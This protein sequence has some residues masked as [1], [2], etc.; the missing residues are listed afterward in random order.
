MSVKSYK[1][2]ARLFR[3]VRPEAEK[4][5]SAR[6]QTIEGLEERLLLTASPSVQNVAP[7]ANATGVALNAPITVNVNLPNGGLAPNSVI[8]ANVYLYPSNNSS[9]SGFVPS[10][11]NTTGGGDAIILTPSVNLQ[12]NTKYV[13]SI[14]NGVKDVN[15]DAFTP[16]TESFTTNNTAPAVN[17]SI[18]FQKVALPTTAGVPF[19]DM[20]IGPDSKLYASTEDGRIFRFVINSD[21]TLGTP[22]IFTTLQTYEGGNRLITGFAFDPNSTATN[23][24]L[25]V[26]NTYYALSGATN[27]PNFTSKLT[28]M[29]GANLTNVVDAVVNLPRSVADHVND[30]PVFQ[31]GTSN[32]FFCQAGQNAYGAPDTTWGNRAETLLS[33]AILEVN[34]AALNLS[35]PALNVLTPDVGGTYNPYAAAAPVTIYA[36]GVRNAFSLY[37]DST[38]QLWA[39]LNGSSSGGNTP[40]FSSSNASQ[41]NGNR[42]DTGAPYAGPNVPGL[43]NVPQVEDD[44]LA[45]IVQGGYY[46]HPDPVRGE[47]VLDDGNP[48][49]GGV[50]GLVFTNYP[51]GTNPD[52]NYRVSDIFIMG[53][54][55]SPDAIFAYTA[56]FAAPDPFGGAL[57]NK[58]LIA[59]YSAGDDIAVVSRTAGDNVSTDANQNVIADRSISGFSA[60]TNPLALLE[61]PA[62][63]YIYVSELGGNDL[64]LLKP[65]AVPVQ[66][67]VTTLAGNNA[68]A[69]NTISTGYTGATASRVETVTITNTGTNP[70][71]FG[72]GALSIINDPTTTAN[73]ARFT[74]TNAASLP[75]SLAAGASFAISLKYTATIVGTQSAILQI[76]SNDP[77]NPTFSVNLHGIGTA[78]QYGV[79]EPSLVQVLRANNIPTIVGAGPNDVNINTQKYPASPDPSSEEVA[80]QRMVVAGPGPVTI[81]PIAS[82]ST[83]T[84]AVS[85]IGY[86]TPGDPLDDTELFYIAKADAQTVSPSAVGATSFN[87]GSAPFSL[88][89]TFPGTTTSNGSLDTHY[90]EDAFNTLDP[91]NERKFRFFPMKTANG[92]VVPNTYIVAIE[93]Y[94]DPTTYNSFINF[95]GIISNVRPA[96]NAN[97]G[98]TP[99]SPTGNNLPVMGVQLNGTAPGS[100]NLVFNTINIPNP[101]APDVVHNTNT[102]TINNTGD[103]PLVITSLTLSDTKNWTLVNPPASGTSIAGGGSLTVT[104]KF[105]ATTNPSHTANETNDIATDSGVSSVAAG[106]VWTGTLTINSNDPIKP[107]QK[108]SLTGYWQYQT[109]HENEP[110]LPTITNLLLGYTTNDTGAASTQGTELLNNGNTV[111]MY[112]SEVDPSTDQGL[113]VAADPTQP[114]SLLEAAAFH[115][116]YQTVTATVGTTTYG[117]Q[118]ASESGTTVTITTTGPNPFKPGNQ[119]TIAGVAVAGYNGTF[120][121]LATPTP[122]TFTY[123]AKA[124]LAASA[125]APTSPQ[126]GWYAVGSTSSHYLFRDQAN[127]GQSVFPLSTNDSYSTVQTSFTPTGAFGLSL[128]G[129]KSQDSLNAAV[130]TPFNTGGHAL[131]FFPVIDSTGKIVPNTWLVTM[132]YRDYAGPNSDYQDLVEI[133]TNATFQALPPTPMDLQATQGTAGVNLQWAAMNGATGYNVYQVVNGTPV[134]LNPSPITTASYTDL[135]APAGSVVKYQVIAVNAAGAQSLAASTSIN[136]AGYTAPAPTQAP[137]APATLTATDNSATQVTLGWSAVIGASSY[138]VQRQATGDATWTTLSA[139]FTNGTTFVD[140]SALPSTNYTYQVAAQNSVGTSSFTQAQTTTIAAT[141]GAYQSADISSTPAGSTIV[142][143]DSVSYDVSAYGVDIGSTSTDSF[144]FVYQQLTGNFD[145]V[146]QVQSLVNTFSTNKAGLMARA[147]LD[148]GSAMVFDGATSAS[149]FRWLYRTAL[150]ATPS[151]N[152]V[153]PNIAFPNVWVRLKRV[154]NVFT[155]YYSTDGL[156]WTQSGTVTLA[157]PTT[158]YFGMAVSSHNTSAETTAQFRSLSVLVPPAAPIAT[159]TANSTS[160][161]NVSW[162]SV[163]TAASYT[164]LRYN[165]A[166]SQ[167]ASIATGVTTTSYTDSGLSAGT[168]YQYEVM[169]VNGVG[170][171]AASNVASVTTP[172]GSTPT[173]PPAPTGLAGTS[174]SHNEIDLTWTPAAGATSYTLQ[175]SSDGGATW[176]TLPGSVTTASFQDKTTTA[177][178]AYQYEVIATNSAGSSPA[179]APFSISAAPSFTSADIG[180]PLAGSTST[181]TDDSAYDVTAGGTGIYANADSFRYIYTQVTGNFDV[182]VQ[183]TNL[184]NPGVT[185]TYPQAGLL[186]RASLDPSSADVGI[187]ASTVGGYRFKHRDTTAAATT[188]TQTNSSISANFPSVWLRMT[189]VGNLFTTYYSTDGVHWTTMG[190]VT[191]TSLSA[192]SPIYIGMA[193]ASNTNSATSTASFRNFTGA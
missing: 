193:V 177:G 18:A 6:A 91:T 134:L 56:P 189:R 26:S 86:Y 4:L 8:G 98:S 158:I 43:T 151:F 50:P 70:L 58:F 13:F 113:L 129:E 112:G 139:A 156:T 185:G 42:I 31:P 5:V 178:T 126:S 68:V 192:T 102:I 62:N 171:S 94:N 48:T 176:T 90:S 163:P 96:P 35:G 120:T 75:A 38:G 49:S 20:Q 84:A 69:F 128:D 181:I 159:A 118:S 45:K 122:S 21:G 29:S 148:A 117:I 72:S 83:N 133:L 32:L 119:V 3:A 169:A 11:V 131:R 153:G 67:T 121:I 1:T 79:L 25:W 138:I 145:A 7:A 37:F 173:A 107:S 33:A 52:P 76:K 40:A 22:Q 85:R 182:A 174:P 136:L 54:H 24:I 36:T 30:Q 172:T 71:T 80:M 106:G 89:A 77:V 100:T 147:T 16:Y 141:T 165:P 109:E 74:I 17:P 47:Y 188:Q 93:D 164:V 44:T 191:L 135:T 146:V 27:G 152:S 175:R 166:T 61:N 170:S 167:Y 168:M 115:Q 190:S 88:Y 2:K 116:Q 103:Q 64:V 108:V 78:G 127:N 53:Q 124:G 110:G 179:S 12:P 99:S 142:N 9:N 150:N 111:I 65:T 97:Q 140:T 95:V 143:V 114:V 41:I 160:A 63:G 81:T 46:G 92:T 105:I 101:I 57:N 51:L 132:D 19:T 125:T 23:P 55:L 162:N 10:V 60:F 154:G 104:I 34:T 144:R 82:F 149:S 15:G 180:A 39:V 184:T 66:I 187:T 130:D 28:V 183:V 14:T 87:P 157:L 186:A 59:E 155:G 137:A 73:A 123:T 161:V